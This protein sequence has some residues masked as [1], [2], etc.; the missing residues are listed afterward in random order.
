MYEIRHRIGVEA[1][2]QEVYD[3]IA[4]AEGTRRWW[5]EDVTLTG[6]PGVGGELTFGFGGDRIVTMVLTELAPPTKIVW[7][8]T[9][10]PAEWIGGT[11]TFELKGDDTDAETVVLFTNSG[12][13][14]PVEFMHHCSTAWAYYLL[15]L[16]HDV[17]GG[18]GTPWPGNEPVSSWN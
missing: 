15:S 16:K 3:A 18:K 8:C 14:E 9:A 5:T 17:G 11:F 1:P 2:V 6:G 7:R 13:R 12:W 10:G 4:T